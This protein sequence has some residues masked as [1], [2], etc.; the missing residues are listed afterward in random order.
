MADDGLRAYLVWM[1]VL[2]SDD[3]PAAEALARSERDGRARHYWAPTRALGR[4]WAR[5]APPRGEPLAWDVV[6]LFDRGAR[7]TGSE[8][9]RPAAVRYPASMSPPGSPAFD[10]DELRGAVRQALAR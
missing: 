4:A 3:R 1:P 7:W 2:A 6:M 10:P 9:P 5:I 8:L